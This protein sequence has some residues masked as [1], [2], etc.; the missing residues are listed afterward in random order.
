LWNLATGRE[1]IRLTE[2]EELEGCT[3][4]CFAF[5]P[6]KSLLAGYFFGA[7]GYDTIELWDI[8]TGR[9]RRVFYG[10]NRPGSE[11]VQGAAVLCVDFSADG[12]LLAAAVPGGGVA[13]W[14]VATGRMLHRLTGH[15]R[16]IKALCFSGDG[17]LLATASY[18]GTV[19]L[20]ELASGKERYR[21]KVERFCNAL[22]FA[23]DGRLLAFSGRDGTVWLRDGGTG[24]ERPLV[25]HRGEV[26]CLAFS[27]DGR[28]LVS[29]S[30]D[31]TAL[32]W[33]VRKVVP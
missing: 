12:K 16:R 2:P 13:V 17:R 8:A 5:S 28:F 9:L 6:D 1:L 21:R 25:G 14:S 32:V 31:T 22:A 18:D 27:A 23:P 26:T 11:K 33:D 29:G 10:A 20:W 3:L 19:R 24:R 15:D 4:G 30:A 7:E